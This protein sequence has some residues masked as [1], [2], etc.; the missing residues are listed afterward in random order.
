MVSQQWF[1]LA[2]LAH[3]N[4]SALPLPLLALCHA[5]ASFHWDPSSRCFALSLIPSNSNELE[6]H[7]TFPQFLLEMNLSDTSFLMANLRVIVQ[8][9]QHAMACQARIRLATFTQKLRTQSVQQ[10][11]IALQT[12]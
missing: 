3:G 1:L 7:V 11:G 9:Q 8:F 5:L 4:L 6:Q 10:V 12:S 2:F